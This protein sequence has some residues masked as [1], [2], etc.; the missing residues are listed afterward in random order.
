[1]GPGHRGKVVVKMGAIWGEFW[2]RLGMICGRSGR[3]FWGAFVG[4]FGGM[5]WRQFG[6]HKSL[7]GAAPI[8][9]LWLPNCLQIIPP[10]SPTNAPPNCPPDRPQIIPNR[11]PNS[12]QIA[13]ILTTTFPRWPG[14]IQNGLR[15]IVV[16]CLCFCLLVLG[17]WVVGSESVLK[18]WSEKWCYSILFQVWAAEL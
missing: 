11:P 16:V 9:D 6:S 13:P 7:V 14:P 17:V 5:F 1:M 8:N 3:Q 18:D 10:N 4:L 12:P 15:H 2:G